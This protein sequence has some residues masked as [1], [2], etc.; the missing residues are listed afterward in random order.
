MAQA[1]G[2]E[3]FIPSEATVIGE[4]MMCQSLL[5]GQQVALFHLLQR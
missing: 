4:R 3:R 1:P 2:S 5:A